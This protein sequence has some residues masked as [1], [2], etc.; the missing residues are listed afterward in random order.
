M[1]LL[2]YAHL[3]LQRKKIERDRIRQQST[4]ASNPEVKNKLRILLHKPSPLQ[5]KH[6]KRWQVCKCGACA[7]VRL[8]SHAS[9]SIEAADH[10][11]VRWKPDRLRDN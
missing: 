1:H 5:S 10:T 11:S 8:S 7:C 4:D 3:A 9:E 2:T 6:K